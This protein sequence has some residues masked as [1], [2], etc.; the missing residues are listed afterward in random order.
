MPQQVI[1]HETCVVVVS[2]WVVRVRILASLRILEIT[3]PKSRNMKC[4]NY[5]SLYLPDQG[6]EKTPPHHTAEFKNLQTRVGR[7]FPDLF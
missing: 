7:K 2:N 5:P 4:A 1:D 6:S 3:A